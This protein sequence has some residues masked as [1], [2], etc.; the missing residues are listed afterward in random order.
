MST[1]PSGE[2]YRLSRDEQSVVV[3]ELGATLRSYDVEG[4]SVIDGFAAD[5]RP[6]GGRGQVLAPWPNRVRDGRYTFAGQD[7][8]LALNE[9]A[10]HNAIH[11]L[12][13]WVGWRMSERTADAVTLTTHVWPQPGYPF[14]LHLQVTYAL[15]A[16]GLEVSVVARNDGETAAPYGVGH[17]PYL[18]VGAPIDEAVLT[19]PAG[20][21][22]LVDDRGNPV[23][24]EPVGGTPYDFREPRRIRGLVLDVAYR[25]LQPDG[26]GLARVRLEHADRAAELWG[27]EGVRHLQLFSGDTLPEPSRR[28]ASLAVEPMSCPPGALASGD[29][30]VRLAPGE[31]HILRWG[32]RGW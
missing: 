3:T 5:G 6:D 18:T 23:G 25:D 13:R 15:T 2:Q 32:L 29:D 21:R 12:V 11:G 8:Q 28:R 30:L 19:V 16:G 7:H 4:R 9:V 1:R 31:S 24:E 14:L 10:N 22:V 20:R 26:D 17:H 27:G